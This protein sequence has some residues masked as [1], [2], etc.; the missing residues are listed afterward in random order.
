MLVLLVCLMLYNARHLTMKFWPVTFILVVLAACSALAQTVSETPAAAALRIRRADAE[1]RALFQSSD[2]LPLTL[3]AN[4]GTIT[5]DRD[6]DSTNVYPGVIRLEVPDKGTIEVPVQLSVRGSLR[7][8][9]CDFVPLRV[10]FSKDE[11]RGTVFETRAGGLKLVTHCHN[12]GDDEQYILKEYLAYR[13]GNLMPAPSFRARLARITY[14]DSNKHKTLTKRYAI[15]LEDDSDVARRLQ[16]KVADKEFRFAQLHP[17]ALLEMTLFEFMIGNTDYSI[18]ARHN[19]RVVELPSGLAYPIAY[20]FDVSGLVNV[21]Y[22]IPDPRLHISSLTDRVYRGPCR[23]AEQLQVFLKIFLGKKPD[24]DALIDSVPDL[25]GLN[26]QTAHS[27]LNQFFSTISKPSSVK[28][29]LIDNCV[30]GG[31]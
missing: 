17:V 19:V 16:G 7:R 30:K 21:P 6:P 11:A 22:A 24:V 13:I 15:F 8:K 5:K 9:T 26:R 3:E 23:S 31:N 20:D 28:R 4:F 10:V 12:S 14:V 29:A 2:T 1:S 25:N 18:M 27:F